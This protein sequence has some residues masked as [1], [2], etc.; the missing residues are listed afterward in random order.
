VL[1][2][3]VRSLKSATIT[4]LQSNPKP[5]PASARQCLIALV[6]ARGHL[7]AFSIKQPSYYST[8]PLKDTLCAACAAALVAAKN[9]KRL[10]ILQTLP[11]DV[12]AH[13]RR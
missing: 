7:L 11:H 8:A 1:L 4:N 3:H 10:K 13:H 6:E 12:E 5:L 9:P 2:G